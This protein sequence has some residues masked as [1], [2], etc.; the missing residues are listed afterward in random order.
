MAE[1][2]K[3]RYEKR[4]P[5]FLNNP[6]ICKENR[7]LYKDFLE[8]EEY[9]LPKIN[10]IRKLDN[11]CYKTLYGY[12]GKIQNINIWFNNKPLKKLTEA[13]IKKVYDDLEDGTIKNQA[14]LPFADLQGCYYSK[15]FKST[16]F[17][18]AGKKEIA[19]KV[20]MYSG[21]KDAEVRFIEEE[22]FRK[23]VNSTY[24]PHHRLLLW[25]SW[26][27]GE[28]IN[29]L[30]MLKKGDFRKGKNP[31]TKE[32]EYKVNLRKEI[33]KRTRKSRTEITNYSETVELIEQHLRGLNEEDRLFN[34]GYNFAKKV[35]D[36]ALKRTDVKCIPKGQKVSWKDLRSGMACDLLK[37][38]WS[39]NEIN[40]RLGHKPS[41][42][43]IDKYVSFLAIDR[44]RPKKKVQEFEM[45]KLNEELEEMK[46]REKLQASRNEQLQNE[47]EDLQ[48]QK[49]NTGTVAQEVLKLI[50]KDPKILARAME[51]QKSKK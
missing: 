1:N 22:D 36:R 16:L 28:N 9:K 12:I 49:V 51:I 11:S 45:E 37:K 19:K 21:N 15:I 44:H 47:V 43:V 17:E 5:K 7:Q 31:Y 34:F 25:L 8:E 33:L 20:I 23:I 4:K 29:S 48:K 3:T 40:S 42:D 30:L 32:P 41:S 50:A 39:T 24:K 35:I 6:K 18:M 38:G 14:G 46:K 13:D 27:I 2:F 26:D 10:D